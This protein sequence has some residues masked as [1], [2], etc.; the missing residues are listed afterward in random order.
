MIYINYIYLLNIMLT[1]DLKYLLIEY[2]INRPKKFKSFVDKDEINWENLSRNP[3]AIHLLEKNM[4]KINWNWLS[5]N[6]AA[7]H[8][9]EEKL[10]SGTKSEYDKVNWMCLS[11]N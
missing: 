9:L 4:K 11:E 8:L 5:R 6:P 10:K 3:A 1:K 2:I 7:L